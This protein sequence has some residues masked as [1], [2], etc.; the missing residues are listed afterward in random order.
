MS[1]ASLQPWTARLG[2]GSSEEVTLED[3]IKLI[4]HAIFNGVSLPLLAFEDEVV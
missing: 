4:D 3:L 2:E 1:L